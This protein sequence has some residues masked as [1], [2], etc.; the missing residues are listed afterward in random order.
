MNRG[1]PPT[2]L[3]ALTGELTPPGMHFCARSN[4]AKL[5]DSDVNDWKEGVI[6]ESIGKRLGRRVDLN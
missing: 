4:K 1:V 2:A 5:W 3:K 6:K